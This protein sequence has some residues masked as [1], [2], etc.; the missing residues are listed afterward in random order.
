MSRYVD[1]IELLRWERR[2]ADMVAAALREYL[3]IARAAVLPSLTAD[4]LGPIAPDAGA[5]AATFEQ[6]QEILGETVLPGVE[7][8]MAERILKLS[9]D[10]GISVQDAADVLG[11]YRQNRTP[12]QEAVVEEAYA[13][14]TVREWMETYMQ[15][16]ENK[17]VQTPDSVFQQIAAALDKGTAKGEGTE[18]L[19][20]RVQDVLDFNGTLDWPR[21]AELVA[22]TETTGAFNAATLE[23][24][25]VQEKTLGITLEKAWVCTIDGRTRDDHFAADGQRVPLDGVFLVGGHEMRYPGDKNAP[26]EQIANCRCAIVELE[27][28]DPLPDESDR[29]TERGPTD[30]V[31]KHRDGSRQDEIDRRARDGVTRARDE[32]DGSLRASAIGE[33][34]KRNWTGRLVPIGEASGD[35]RIFKSGGEF[36]FRTF[37]LP[38]MHQRQTS[39][40]H[41]E[42]VTVGSIRSAEVR[43]DGIYGEGV[44]FDTPEA[45]EA[46]AMLE[47]GV[48]RPSIDWCDETWEL[49]GTDGEPVDPETLTPETIDDVLYQ[50]TGMT[51]MAA[52][53]VSKPAFDGTYVQ[54]DSAAAVDDEDDDSETDD[55]TDER[56]DEREDDDDEDAVALAASLLAAGGPGVPVFDA[57]AFA[58]PKLTEVTGIRAT[59]DG[60]VVGH[61]ATWNQCHV[62]VGNACVVAPRSKTGYAL[63]H[64]SEVD[65]TDGPVA[66]GRLTVGAGHADPKAGV[67]PARE[68]YDNAA[69]C[70]ALGRV[71]EDEHGIA[72]AGVVHPEATTRQIM[73]GTSAPLSGDW[74]RHG[75]NLE[76]V[77]ALTVNTPGFPVV[78]GAAD[79]RGRDLSLVAAGVVPVGND[80]GDAPLAHIVAAA[81]KAAVAEYADQQRREAKAAAV[82]GRV[83]ERID[84]ESRERVAAIAARREQV[85]S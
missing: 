79:E 21:R 74:R 6:W 18:P 35:R 69:S 12:E 17:M 20:D 60:R 64:V 16:V 41:D 61:V 70:W 81:A 37:P 38:L 77:A 52:T 46:A 42:S 8:L 80:E 3:P 65:T 76:L 72:F 62:G 82:A 9:R 32:D 5:I 45:S 33:N 15:D 28:D 50:V 40:G 59:S 13:I 85:L 34:M 14:P 4:G 47:E 58:D 48:T 71:Y 39:G 56:E 31:V 30:S 24:A 7:L 83:R 73:D 26:V 29:Q 44:L 36:A 53:L 54:L 63:F 75:G 19:R 43:E 11:L 68:H 25:R 66:V 49:V 2:I 55:E 10:A 78:R 51:L 1:A 27:P 23:A 22:R 57:D 67:V 84:A